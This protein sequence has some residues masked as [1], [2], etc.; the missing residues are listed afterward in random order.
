MEQGFTDYTL[1]TGV[2]R[3]AR[4]RGPSTAAAR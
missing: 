2:E 4:V 3:C 1:A